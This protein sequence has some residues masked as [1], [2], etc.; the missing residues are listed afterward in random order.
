M[1][2]AASWDVGDEKPSLLIGRN[3]VEAQGEVQDRKHARL[4]CGHRNGVALSVGHP[5]G[6][7]RQRLEDDDNRTLLV[8]PFADVHDLAE[9]SILVPH[10]HH[11][12]LIGREGDDVEL[13]SRLWVGV[14]LFAHG[15]AC[16][17]DSHHRLA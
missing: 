2:V 16:C 15:A 11:P 7:G 1:V 10:Y 3:F 17:L 8:V 12:I 4:D 6:D 5:S 9:L 13:S 14:E